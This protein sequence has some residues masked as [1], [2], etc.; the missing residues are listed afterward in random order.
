VIRVMVISYL[1]TQQHVDALWEA[2]LA[3]AKNAAP[4]AVAVR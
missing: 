1:T 3:A 4:K 2:L